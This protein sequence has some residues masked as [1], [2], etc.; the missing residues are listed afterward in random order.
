MTDHLD[1]AAAAACLRSSASSVS[2]S[3]SYDTRSEGNASHGMASSKYDA[4]SE[5]TLRSETLFSEKEKRDASDAA[6]E[7]SIDAFDPPRV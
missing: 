7:K 5:K 6:R 3:R 1:I 4:F 2:P